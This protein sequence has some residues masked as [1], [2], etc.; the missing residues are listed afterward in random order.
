MEAV[1]ATASILHMIEAV[2][3]ATR[4]IHE[5]KGGASEREK[6][7]SELGRLVNL[8]N[9]LKIKANEAEQ[10]Q[11]NSY[12]GTSALAQPTGPLA[13]LQE[14]TETL[15]KLLSPYRR[16]EG[17]STSTT[18]TAVRDWAFSDV[19]P[20]LAWPKRKRTYS[21][22]LGDVERTKSL[23]SLALQQDLM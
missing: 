2:S 9:E 19:R 22:T 6:L 5:V 13:A 11:P 8:L 3:S 7:R 18:T 20:G 1:S 12:P 14:S 4:Y 10:Q 17:S 15:S 16:L 23:I 21:E